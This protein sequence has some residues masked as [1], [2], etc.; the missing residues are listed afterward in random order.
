MGS[1]RVPSSDVVRIATTAHCGHLHPIWRRRRGCR[2]TRG[3]VRPCWHNQ[4]I[5][6]ALTSQRLDEKVREKISMGLFI[7]DFLQASASARF[8]AANEQRGL[9]FLPEAT[10]CTPPHALPSLVSCAI[11]TSPAQRS[12]ASSRLTCEMSPE[13]EGFPYHLSPMSSAK[14]AHR[15]AIRH[16][17]REGAGDSW[18]QTS[19]VV[20]DGYH[21]A[22][23][24]S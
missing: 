6:E 18:V 14:F 21:M 17:R 16:G 23:L 13:I 5:S 11:V 9:I 7:R 15:K 22:F 8:A 4:S 19:P 3:E 10:E 20:V 2:S 1:C 12:T 24:G